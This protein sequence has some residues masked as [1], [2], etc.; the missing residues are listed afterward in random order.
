MGEL[1]A[2]YMW[3]LL[4]SSLLATGIL[5]TKVTD[6]AF[7]HRLPTY[8][9]LYNVITV[10]LRMVMPTK[11]LAQA[12]NWMNPVLGV[13]AV[14]VNAVDHGFHVAD[15]VLRVAIRATASLL[16]SIS[17]WVVLGYIIG[18]L[19]DDRVTE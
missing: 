7:K 2:A 12:M 15:P 4:L 8:F 11:E 9:A 6:L 17:L 5:A 14:V 10:V 1:L 19:L 16:G 3:G 18:S 13:A